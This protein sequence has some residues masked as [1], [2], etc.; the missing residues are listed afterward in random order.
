MAMRSP[1]S[2]RPQKVLDHLFAHADE[3]SFAQNHN[4]QVVL[5]FT[6]RAQLADENYCPGSSQS[7]TF[8]ARLQYQFT[9]MTGSFINVAGRG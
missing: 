4:V 2:G 1:S 5:F 9:I 8:R 6:F 7:F 3:G